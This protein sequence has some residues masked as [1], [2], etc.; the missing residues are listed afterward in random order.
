MKYLKQFEA[1]KIGTYYKFPCINNVAWLKDKH[2]A[3]GGG[4][5][6]FF[7]QLSISDP[8]MKDYVIAELVDINREVADR[9]FGT[10]DNYYYSRTGEDLSKIG[11]QFLHEI[12]FLEEVPP[13]EVKKYKRLKITNRFGL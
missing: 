13:E 3:K 1:Y 10:F 12:K 9:A 5:V 4:W 11:G 6:N 8:N 7:S 2:G